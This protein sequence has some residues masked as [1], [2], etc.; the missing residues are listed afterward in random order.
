MLE[1]QEAKG[2][3]RKVKEEEV[4]EGGDDQWYLP[5]FPVV[6]QDKAT[7]KVRVV[8]DAAAKYG[9]SL[10]DEMHAGPKLQNDLVRVLIRFCKEPVALVADIAEMFLQVEVAEKDR[11]YLRFLWRT[12]PQSRPE[13]FEFT[14]LVFGL[15]ASPYLAG[16]ALKEFPARHGEESNQEVRRAVDESVYVDDLLHSE[17]TVQAAI[18]T[19]KQAQETLDRGGF[20]LR[21]WMS[22]YAKV[23]ATIP[24]EDRTPSKSIGISDNEHPV[25]PSVKTLGVTWDAGPDTFRLL[26]QS[27]EDSEY[28]RRTVL[29]RMASILTPADSCHHLR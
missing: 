1:A 20:H 3:N 24:E 15:K 27:P 11:K 25:L 10:N 22:T 28:T 2:Y 9:K 14:R 5:H 7:T 13:V 26:Y 16:K 21:K 23:L 29:K 19:C 4:Q 6:Q 12:D 8:Y 18:E 17:P